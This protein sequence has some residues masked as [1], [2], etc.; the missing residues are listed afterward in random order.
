M[1]FRDGRGLELWIVRDCG[2]GRRVSFFLFSFGRWSEY[3]EHLI[4]IGLCLNGSARLDQPPSLS[5]NS[6]GDRGE[7]ALRSAGVC[8]RLSVCV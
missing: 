7:E 4:V 3:D 6:S 5:F 2:S 8:V 1:Q